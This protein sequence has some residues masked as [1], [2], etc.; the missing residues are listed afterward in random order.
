MPKSNKLNK[1]ILLTAL[2]FI[3][4]QSTLV[5]SAPPIRTSGSLSSSFGQRDF[6]GGETRTSSWINIATI[7][8]SSYI[9]QP[10]FALVNGSVSL[11]TIEQNS[12]SSDTKTEALFGNLQFSL[13][14]S[15]RFPFLFYA[16]K[17]QN[18]TKAQLIDRSITSTVVGL[19]QKY[20]NKR[21][22]QSYSGSYEHTK[23]DNFDASTTTNDQIKFAG[24][25]RLEDNLLSSSLDYS[26]LK[27][28]IELDS[29]NYSF[30]ARHSFSGIDNLSVE[31]LITA[32]QSQL[33][34]INTVS[35]TKNDQFSSYITWKPAGR[36][37]L[38]I[39]GN[40]LASNLEQSITEKNPSPSG[41]PNQS[42]V[43]PFIN[44]N[45]G[46]V[47]N[48]NNNIS[49]NQSAN[50]NRSKAGGDNITTANESGSISYTSDTLDTDIGTYNWNI[51]SSLNQSHGSDTPSATALSVQTGHTFSKEFTVDEETKLSASINQS[52]SYSTSTRVS[53]SSALSHS[54]NVNWSKTIPRNNLSIRLNISDSR[55]DSAGGTTFRL[56]NIQVNDD[57][58]YGRNTTINSSLT[59]Q[60][61]WQNSDEDNATSQNS[62]GQIGLVKQRFLNIPTLFFNSV[63]KFS[64]QNTSNQEEFIAENTSSNDNSWENKLTYRIGL[65]EAKATLDF[66][67]NEGDYDQIF[68]I[69]FTRYFGVQ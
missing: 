47:Y 60:K 30:S 20:T 32:T 63:L 12:D 4:A 29:T 35:D 56:L 31:N 45:Q 58:R 48:Y 40:F 21:G 17:S 2:I 9:W 67:K 33:D 50:V 13:F 59:F 36:S 16:S 5:Y 66:L 10:W 44:L 7:S 52:I 39:T 49:I 15:S 22:N 43:S 34:F 46:L 68:T 37:D 8:A 38:H 14:P 25:L 64:Q 42:S 3:F 23:R 61:T 6:N 62:N 53:D 65:L 1:T 54:A 18:D 41:D 69:Q 51:S 26:K 57:Y 11:S 55:N 24:R 19:S 28:T 27:S